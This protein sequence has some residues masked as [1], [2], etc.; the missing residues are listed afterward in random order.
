MTIQLINTGTSANAGNGDTLRTAFGKI[1]INFLEVINSLTN[2][3]LTPGPT[4]PT[5]PASIIPGPTGPT[6]PTG[7]TGATGPTGLT[8]ATGPTGS[9]GAAGKGYSLTSAQ[10]LSLS[11]GTKTLTVNL[12]NQFSAYIV[13]S[14]VRLIHSLNTNIWMEG[15][16]TSYSNNNF[17][18]DV[19]LTNGAAGNYSGWNI[20]IT[21]QPGVG[22][23]GSGDIT[24]STLT[25]GPYSLYL[26]NSGN[27]EVPGHILPTQTLSY[28]IGSSNYRWRSLY[29][30]T[31]T[32]YLGDNSVTIN[33]NGTLLINN[34]D[35]NSQLNST[36]IAITSTNVTNWNTAYNWG[37]HANIGYLTEEIDPV[38]SNSAAA[39]ITPTDVVNWDTAY[40]WGNHANIGY[41]TT[42]TEKDP[43]FST[44]TA[45]NITATNVTNWNTA[46]SW[47]NHA[48][49]G[50]L[51]TASSIN[52]LADVDTTTIPPSTGQV[53]K[54]VGSNWVPTDVISANLNLPGNLTFLDN[55]TQTTAYNLL[56]TIP[57]SSTSDGI[58]GQMA[59]STTSLYVCVATNS[60]LKF[61]GTT[62]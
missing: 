14:R 43:I 16:L 1:N 57:Q 25:N 45:A 41:L 2:I 22:N 46:Y 61:D 44:S 62:F 23:S 36:L 32:I 5:G 4:G 3:S 19:T 21:G 17:V 31:S 12:F 52:L 29:I 15:I 50:Y 13:G 56:D 54:W 28:D 33:E 27:L 58:K 26:N 42:T 55:T 18:V 8:G 48:N 10:T 20:S 39:S 59:V 51:T 24:T 11:N 38:Y 7:L 37:N 6:G 30:S 40:S 60:W 34:N 53:L 47:G 49:I 35:I 9:P